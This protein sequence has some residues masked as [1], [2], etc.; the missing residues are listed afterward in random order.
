MVSPMAGSGQSDRVRIEALME[1]SSETIFVTDA[2]GVVS[3]VSPSVRRVLGYEPGAIVGR[4]HAELFPPEEVDTGLA[5]IIYLYDAPGA[6]I[7]VSFRNRHADGTLRWLRGTAHNLLNVPTIG[8]IVVTV[9]DVT[10]DLKVEQAFREMVAVVESSEDAILATTLDGTITSWNAAA[11]ALTRFARD[12]VVGTPLSSLFAPDQVAEAAVMLSRMA[13][14]EMVREHTTFWQRSDGTTVPVHCT[15]SPVRGDD[16]VVSGMSVVARQQAAEAIRHAALHDP[17]TNLPNRDLLMDRLRTALAQSQRRAKRI[18][19]LII[20]LDSF[21]DVNDSLGHATGDL[22]LAE[23]A[24]RLAG[25][26]RVG[27]TVARFGGDELV[28][29]RETSD[30]EETSRFA[31]R[32]LDCMTEPMDLGAGSEIFVSA[33]IGAAISRPDAS[34][35]DLVR[36]ADAALYRAKENGR[37]AIEFF[38]EDLRSRARSR[39][40]LGGALRRALERGELFLVHQPVVTLGNITLRGSE[41]LIRW[42]H[43]ERGVISPLDFIPLAEETGLIIPV[44]E[45]VL[46]EA[47]RQMAGWRRKYAM[48]GNFSVSVNLSARQLASPDLVATVSTAL[49]SSAVPPE[50]VYLE[51]TE[52]TLLSQVASHMDTLRLL[53]ELGVHLTVDDFGTGYSSL[54]YLRQLPIDSLKIDRSFIDG[55]GTDSNDTAIVEA[56]LGLAKVLDLDVVAEGVE[57]REQLGLL[58][59]MGCRTGQGFLFSEPLDSV[60]MERFLGAAAATQG[61]L[62]GV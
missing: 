49:S 46:S 41:A 52:T 44:G 15:A 35:E 28:I 25:A 32:L 5:S 60:D 57:T 51:I 27:D 12:E 56:V 31:A 33:C 39:V 11:T 29:V 43:P 13:D 47:I 1:H 59:E 3:Y 21:K 58:R 16:G 34:A 19:V 22:V 37:S 42:A 17:L 24:A 48:A 14:G 36:E 38:D 9:S 53:R 45:W 26:V 6:I 40:D 54:S 50:C 7:P 61:R 30:E 62:A 18:A 23:M 8:G 20:D 2:F 10:D 4:R 55:L